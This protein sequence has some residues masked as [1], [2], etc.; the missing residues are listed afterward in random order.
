MDDTQTFHAWI[1][2]TLWSVSQTEG[3]ALWYSLGF[4]IA[5]KK[6]SVN[7]GKLWWIPPWWRVSSRPGPQLNSA[8]LAQQAM[9]RRLV[10]TCDWFCLFGNILITFDDADNNKK[11][12]IFNDK[13]FLEETCSKIGEWRSKAF[14]LRTTTVQAHLFK[15]MPNTCSDE[16]H[17]FYQISVLSTLWV[18]YQ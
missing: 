15:T 9:G 17:L 1:S 11:G 14:A 16:C 8:P 13:A 7:I 2:A 18:L 5:R 4:T 12:H 3:S 6:Q 10:N